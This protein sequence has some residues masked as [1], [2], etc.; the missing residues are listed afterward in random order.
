[1]EP[2]SGIEPELGAYQ[3]PVLPLSLWRLERVTGLEPASSAW[4][5][6]ALPLDDTRSM[7]SREGVEPS[8]SPVGSLVLQTSH[9]LPSRILLKRFGA[10]TRNRTAP[11]DMASP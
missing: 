2:P 7:V 6:E 1:M 4:K 5:A 8:R 3:A 11:S 10:G 9:A